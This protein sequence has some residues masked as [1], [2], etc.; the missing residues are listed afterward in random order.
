[1]WILNKNIR[2]EYISSVLSKLLVALLLYTIHETTRGFFLIKKKR[3]SGEHQS[4]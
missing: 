1:M 4:T 2:M 3:L